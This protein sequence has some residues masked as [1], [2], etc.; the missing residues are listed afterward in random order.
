MNKPDEDV[1]PSR[2]QFTAL[3]CMT[4]GKPTRGRRANGR[5]YL[6]TAVRMPAK[7]DA[8]TENALGIT[9]MAIKL[10]RAPIKQYS[11]AV[12]PRLSIKK[13]SETPPFVAALCLPIM[14]P[15]F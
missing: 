4:G 10:I 3:T 6:P 13:L 2:R 14:L 15:I 9:L 1:P 7:L 12:T 5:A 8:T 11:M